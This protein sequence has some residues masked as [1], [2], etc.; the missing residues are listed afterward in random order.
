M[1]A[2]PARITKPP[3]EPPRGLAVPV[4]FSYLPPFPDFVEYPTRKGFVEEVEKGTRPGGVPAVVVLHGPPGVGKSMIAQYVAAT[5]DFG[6]GWILNAADAAT[7]R[8]SL[9]RAQAAE[10]AE[11]ADLDDPEAVRALASE[12]L[13]RLKR[14]RRALG[15]GAGKLRRGAQ[16]A[17]A[18]QSDAHSAPQR[19]VLDRDHGG[20]RRQ[21]G[22]RGP[23][24]GWTTHGRKAG[25]T[26][27]CPSSITLTWRNSPFRTRC[28]G[29][30]AD[31]R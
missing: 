7:L 16:R 8:K 3:Y 2:A 4:I 6:Y 20:E 17:R 18:A 27:A 30:S 22:F 29:S 10:L 13:R 9:A 23:A 5:A 31:G 24:A 19:S 15:R 28:A 21:S 12:A 1:Q 25:S 14:Q 11:L 26:S